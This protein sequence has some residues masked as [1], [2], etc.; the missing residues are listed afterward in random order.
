MPWKLNND[1][2]VERVKALRLEPVD[3]EWYLYDGDVVVGRY[4]LYGEAE[5]AYA[6]AGVDI[7]MRAVIRAIVED[8]VQQLKGVFNDQV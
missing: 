6:K 2:I 4:P 5:K 3:R 7:V 1:E 8:I